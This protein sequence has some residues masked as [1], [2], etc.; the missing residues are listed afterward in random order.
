MPTI[1]GGSSGKGCQT[2]VG[3]WGCRR[4]HFLAV[5]V[6]ISSETLERRPTLYAVRQRPTIKLC[7]G[8][9]TAPHV[10]KFT[11]ASRSSACDSTAFLFCLCMYYYDMHRQLSCSL[12]YLC[13]F[14]TCFY[15]TFYEQIKSMDEL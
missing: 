15:C 11:A 7:C 5:S 1:V 9:K 13:D 10:S 12:A 8:R 6:A 3:E 2:T 14:L 4:R